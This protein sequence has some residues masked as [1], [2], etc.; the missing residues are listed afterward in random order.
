[1][2]RPVP[3]LAL[4]LFLSPVAAFSPLTTTPAAAQPR[5][6]QGPNGVEVHY[7]VKHDLSPPLTEI[8]R[9][10]V[11]PGRRLRPDFEIPEGFQAP[12]G[13]WL[14]AMPAG[15][16]YVVQDWTVQGLIPNPEHTFEGLNNDDNFAVVGTRVTPPDTNGDIG[17][18][19]YVQSVNLIF[20]VYDRQ[21]NRLLGPLRNS[22]PFVGFGGDCE[23]RNNGDPIILYDHLADRW[24]LSQFTTA[25]PF[26]QCIAI[27]QTPDPRGA[28]YRYDFV[29]P[30]GRFNDYPKFGVWPDGYYMSAGSRGIPGPT[31]DVFAFERTAMLAGQTARMV[32]SVT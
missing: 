7:A 22:A 12:P 30:S 2:R 31:T 24:L 13:P 25:A 28:W 4:A 26:H 9:A 16:D 8:A 15:P 11:P 6:P 32:W 10:F 14:P 21:G 1:M 29:I 27:S 17:P 18:N 23:T 5:D 19:H 3:R 20:A